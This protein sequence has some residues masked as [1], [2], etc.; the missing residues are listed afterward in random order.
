[1][2][3]GRYIIKITIS[4][5]DVHTLSVPISPRVQNT[6]SIDKERVLLEEEL[7]GGICLTFHLWP[8]QLAQLPLP[9]KFV[10]VWRIFLS[11]CWQ[12]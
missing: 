5:V 2:M 8:M 11:L 3:R 9:D 7:E 1:M 4:I 10:F 6:C 12:I